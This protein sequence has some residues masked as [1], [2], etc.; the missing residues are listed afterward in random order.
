MIE[1][2]NLTVS[3]EG[4][5]LLKDINLSIAEGETRMLF[6]ENGSGKT[7]LIMAIM[8][9]GP[10]KIEGGRILF[11]GEDITGL[12]ANERASRGIGIM[13]QRPPTI[14]GLK[15]KQMLE[16]IERDGQ[17]LDELASSLNFTEFLER[18]LNLGFSGGEIKRAELLQLL[19]QDPDLVLLDEP[20]SGVDLVNIDLIGNAIRSLLQKDI[21][22]E[23]KKAG[24]IITHSG[25]ILDYVEADRGCV[26]VNKT[27]W[28]TGNPHEILQGIRDRG[29]EGCLTCQK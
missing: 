8:G 13:F 1:I 20:E 29:Y 24:L 4:K 12:P 18:D 2:E 9:L 7:S 25:Y 11:K 26:L 17:D 14:R 21:H 5:E 27:I 28:C 15:V 3:I 6:G 10:Y 16:I 22:K 23:R 19:A